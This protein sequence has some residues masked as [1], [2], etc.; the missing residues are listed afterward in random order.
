MPLP[1][2]FPPLQSGSALEKKLS[3]EVRERQV[4]T[5]SVPELDRVLGGGLVRGALVEMV[6]PPSSGRFACVLAVLAAVTSVGMPAS[7]IDL[8]DHLDPQQAAMAGV[9]LARLLWLR[10][11]SAKDALAS[12]ETAIAAAFPLVVLDLGLSPMRGALVTSGG[13]WL[14]LK[15]ASRAHR[16]ALLVSSR[17]PVCGFAAEI[18]LA[19]R[20]QRSSWIQTGPG[21]LVGLLVEL[22]VKLA[23]AQGRS[24]SEK[25]SLAVEPGAMARGDEGEATK[26]RRARHSA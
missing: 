2:D 8:G 3:L 15:R 7:L 4:L 24:A 10:P 21:L 23:R 13:A 26:P 1:V 5:T 11:R 6:G 25:L 17:R 14:R 18:V 12:A 20:R 9:D 19:M 16:A 22:S